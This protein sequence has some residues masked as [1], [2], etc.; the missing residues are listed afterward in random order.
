MIVQA[1]MPGRVSSQ[2]GAQL[3]GVSPQN[4][5]V[6]PNIVAAG[7]GAPHGGFGMDADLL[8]ARNYMQEKIF[9]LLA[10]RHHQRYHQRMNDSQRQKLKDI[11]KR[12]E[13]GLFKTAPSK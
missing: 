13:E 5:N 8:R 9:L 11:V 2:S 12:L 3:P 4:G 6:V 7:S 1:D 10:Q